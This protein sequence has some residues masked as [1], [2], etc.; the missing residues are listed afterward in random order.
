MVKDARAWLGRSGWMPGRLSFGVVLAALAAL[1]SFVWAAPAEAVVSGVRHTRFQTFQVF[2]DAVSVGNTLMGNTVSQPAVNSFLLSESQ[3]ILQGLPSNAGIEGAY[4]FWSGSTEGRPDR[5]ARLVLPNGVTRTVTADTCF[6][7]PVFGGFFYCR[8]DVTALLAANP[9]SA[10]NYNGTV[11][12]G[13]VQA[14]P[15]TLDE[16]GECIEPN[17]C[18]A[19]Y[20]AWSL[21]VVYTDPNAT[22]LRDVTIFDG[23][24]QFDE[25]FSSGI[26]TFAI[27]GFEVANPPQGRFAYFAMEGD[28]LLGV[29]PQ[30]VDSSPDVRCS[31]C[32]DF[33]DFNGTRL[34]DGRGWPN[35]LFNSTT[36]LGVD[37]DSF[38][39]SGLVRSG[40]RSVTITVGS[41]DGNP[42]FQGGGGESFFLGYVLLSLNR[43]APNFRTNATVKTV[44]PS[45]AG[46]GETVFFSITVTN[47]GSLDAT[48]V[49]L[50]DA[51][52]SNLIYVPGSTRVDGAAVADGPGGAAPFASGLSLGTIPFNGDND[53][54]VT[55]RATVRAGVA[56]GTVIPNVATITARELPEPTPTNEATIRVAAPTLGQPTKS[57]QDANG[58]S[59]EPGDIINYTIFI[60]NDSGRTA[61]A[62]T[63]VDDMPGFVQLRSVAPTP[64]TDRSDPNGGLNGTGR[65]EV[66]DILIPAN[67]SGVFI[68]Y[69]VQIDSVE[70]LIAQGVDPASIDGLTIVNQ[71]RVS[72]PF[73]SAALLTDNPATAATPDPTSFRITSS[74]N[75]QNPDTFKRVEDLN[76]GSLVPGDRLRYTISLRNTGNRATSINLS[77]DLPPFVEGFTLE[78]PLAEAT[79]APAPAGANATGRLTVTGL[80]VAGGSR[81][82][83][84]FTVTVR[85]DAPGGSRIGNVAQLQVPAAPTQSR[86]L[87]STVL[88]V[89]SGPDLSGATKEVVGAPPGGFQPGDEVTWRLAVTNTGNRAATNVRLDDDVALNLTFVSA[90]DGGAFNAAQRRVRWTLGDIAAGETRQVTVVTRINSPLANGTRIRNQGV[91]FADNLASG[92]VTDDPST[93]AVDDFTIITV[94]SEPSFVGTT[95]TVED[96]NGGEF[97]PGDR[98]RYRIEVRNT[99]R[100][101]AT[102]VALSDPVDGVRLSVESVGQ[103]GQLGG[104]VIQW[105]PATTPALASVAPGSSVVLDFTARL[106]G[107]LTN[108]EEVRNQGFI[109]SAQT[110]EPVGTD[111]PVTPEVG[112]PTSIF[113]RA[114]PALAGAIKSVVDENQGQPQPGDVL[115]WTIQLPNSGTGPA[116]GVVVSDVV[117]ASLTDVAPLDGGVFDAATRTITWRLAGPI[118]PG[119]Q[120]EVRFRSTIAPGTADG[121]A[122]SNQARVTT[123]DLPGET[124]LSDDPNTAAVDDPTTLVVR[125]QPDFVLSTKFVRNEDNPGAGFQPG[126]TISYELT[127]RNTGSQAGTA[128]Q[129][130]DD[131]PEGLEAIEVQDGGTLTGRQARWSLGTLA[132]GA[133]ETLL[134]R[135][136]IV[137]PIDDGTQIAN[138]AFISSAEVPTPVPTDNPNTAEE[139]D[140]TVF[141]VSSRPVFLGSRKLFTDL[142]AAPGEPVKPGHLLR[143]TIDVINSGTSS[144]RDVVVSDVVDA[145]LVDVTPE[146]GTF[147]AASRTIRWSAA[148]IPALANVAPDGQPIQVAFTARVRLPLDNGTLIA[149][150]ARIA[151]AEI[152]EGELSDDPRTADFPDATTA[153]VVSAADFTAATKAVSPPAA[154]VYRPGDEVTYTLSFTNN[155]DAV[156]SNVV[157]TDVLD[158]SLL[159]VSATDGGRFA[160]PQ[161]TWDRQST[162]ALASVAPGQTVVLR[163]TAALS[164]PLTNGLEVFNQ[165]RIT[166]EGFVNPVVTDDPSTDA[167]D[168]PTLLTVTS[169]PTLTASTKAVRDLDGDGFFEPG[170]VVE[171]TIRVQNDGSDE[172]RSTVVTDQVDVAS[173]EEVTPLDG[174][175]LQ[176]NTITWT[177]AGT[178]G[179][180]SVRPGAAG[181]VSV[182]FRATLQRGLL[183]GARILNQASLSA[184]GAEPTVTDDP[185]TPEVD[186]PTALR[187]TAAPRFTRFTKRVEDLNGGQIEGGDRLRY[188]LTATNDGTQPG[189]L[190]QINDPLDPNL[191]A[192]AA[193]DG[194]AVVGRA[195]QWSL[196]T[197]APGE[198]REVRFEATVRGGVEDGTAIVNQAGLTATS[199]P[200]VLSDDPSTPAEGDATVVVVNA[201]P[202][203]SALTMGVRVVDGGAVAPGALIEYELIVTNTGSGPGR[204]VILRDPIDAALLE[205]IQPSD[206]GRV[207]AGVV[208]WTAAELPILAAFPTTE[209]RRLT[210]R[211]RIREGLPNGVVILNQ[212][213]LIAQDTPE[214][215]SDDPTTAALDDPT[216]ITLAY[217]A[218]AA[219]DKEV[220]DVDGGLAEAG[221]QVEYTLTL[222]NDT[223][224]PLNNAVVEDTLDAALTEV[225]VEGGRFD[226]GTRLVR[227]DAGTNGALGAVAPGGQVALRF[228]ARIAQDAQPG[229]QIANQARASSPQ[230]AG[231]ERRSDD[232]NTAAV[233]DPTVITVQAPALA[234]LNNTTKLV[235]DENGGLVEPG[236]R[237]T[238]EITVRN[239]GRVAA[240]RVALLDPLPRLTRF[241]PGSLFVNGQAAP[242]AETRGQLLQLPLELPDLAPG[243][244]A[245]V[246]FSTEVSEEAPT[247]AVLTNQAIVTA[248]SGG[249][250]G[251]AQATFQVVTDDPTTSAVDDATQA[252]VGAGPNVSQ[253]SKIARIVDQN[254]NDRLDVGELLEYEIR[255]P[256]RGNLP[257]E[258][259]VLTDVLPINTTYMSGTLSIN[260]VAQTDAPGDDVLSVEG[261][262]LTARLGSIDPGTAPVIRFRVRT[263]R[264]PEVINQGELSGDNFP[265]EKT[266]A[267]GSEANGDQPTVTPVGS[268]AG[269]LVVGKVLSDV[270]G[271]RVA[272]GDTLL[273]TITITNA[274]DA[275]IEDAT[276]V[277]ELPAEVDFVDLALAPEGTLTGRRTLELAGFTVPPRESRTVVIRTQLQAEVQEGTRSCNQASVRAL[278]GTLN[279]SSDPAC[280]TVGGVLGAGLVSGLIFEDANANGV[281][282]EA[283]DLTFPNFLVRVFRAGASSALA[284]VVTGDDGGYNLPTLTEG[285]YTLRWF[286]QPTGGA[287]VRFGQIEGVSV[288]D[289]EVSQRNLR[290]DPS[291]RVYNAQ[292]GEV[293]SGA[294]VQLFYADEEPD[295]ALAGKLVAPQDL[296]EGQ[297]GQRTV[298]G[299]YRFDVVPGHVYRIAVVAPS[300]AFVFPSVRIPAEPRI[301]RSSEDPLLV[302]ESATPD[303]SGPTTWF[304]TFNITPDLPPEGVRN[305]HIPLDPL[306]GLIQVDKFASVRTATIGDVVTYTVRVTNRSSRDFIYDTSNNVG[307]IYIQDLLPRGFDYVKGS[308]RLRRIRGGQ[309]VAS[310]EATR[311]GALSSTFGLPVGDL[312]I[313]GP[314]PLELLAGEV[315]ELRYQL[316]VGID[317]KPGDDYLNRA[318]VV[319]ADGRVPISNEGLA[320]VRVTYD[321]IFDQGVVLGRVFCDDNAN[322]ELDAE[323][324]GVHRARVYLDNGWYAVTDA[325][326]LFHFQAVNPGNH[327]IKLDVNTLAPGAVLTTDVRRVFYTTRGLP[328]K[329]DFG[330][331]CPTHWVDAVDV[332][333]SAATQE[334]RAAERRKNFIQ[335]DGS[336]ATYEVKV[337]NEPLPLAKARLWIS[338]GEAA[339]EPAAEVP[340]VAVRGEKLE[341]PLVFNPRV[342]GLEGMRGWA[343]R[344]WRADAADKVLGTARLLTGSGPLPAAL[345]WEGQDGAAKVPVLSGPVG[346]LAEVVVWDADGNAATSAPAAFVV[347]GLGGGALLDETISGD[348]FVAKKAELTRELETRLGALGEKLRG[349]KAKI[350]ITVHTADDGRPEQA[351]ALSRERGDAVKRLLVARY[352]VAAADVEVEGLGDTRPLVPNIGNRERQI[353]RR[354]I[355]QATDLSPATVAGEAPSLPAPT[356]GVA[357]NNE[358]VEV[359]ADGAFSRLLKKPADGVLILVVRGQDGGAATRVLRLQGEAGA[360]A[361]PALLPMPVIPVRGDLKSGT[362][363][364]GTSTTTVGLLQVALKPGAEVY[365]L[366][367]GVLRPPAE[368]TVLAPAGLEVASYQLEILDADGKVIHA[369]TQS[370]GAPT[371]VRWTGAAGQGAFL[372]PGWY[373]AQLTLTT[374]DGQLGAS[375]PALFRVQL[376]APEPKPKPRRGA[377]PEIIPAAPTLTFAPAAFVNGRPAALAP[378]GSFSV[379]A[380]GYSGQRLVVEI[381]RADGARAIQYV[382]VPALY[383]PPTSATPPATP[384]APAEEAAPTDAAPEAAPAGDGASLPAAPVGPLGSAGGVLY[385][386]DSPVRVPAVASSPAAQPQVRLLLAQESGAAADAPV[387]SGAGPKEAGAL[388]SLGGAELEAALASGDDAER[389]RLLAATKA[390]N[391][392]VQ[393]PPQGV[394]LKSRELVVLG[395]TDPTNAITINGATVENLEGTFR[396][397]L[398]LPLGESEVVVEARDADGNTGVIRWPVKVAERA[399]FL[400]AFADTAVGA[401]GAEL[402]NLTA[403]NSTQA[404]GA[405]LYGEAKVYTKGYMSGRQFLDNFFSEYRYTAYFNSARQG[406]LEQFLTDTIK[407]DQYYPIFGDSAESTNDIN[408]RGKLYILVEAD[409]SRLIVGNARPNIQGVHFFRYDRPFYGA[410]LDFNKVLGQHYKT[411]VKAFVSDDD[412]EV[413]HTWNFLQGTGGSLYYLRNRDVVEGSEKVAVVIRDEASG[414]ELARVPMAR[415]VDYTVDYPSGRLLFKS[416]VPSV[417]RGEFLATRVATTR[418]VLDGNPVIVEVSYD[419]EVLAGDPTGTTFGGQV[420]ETLFDTVSVGAGYVEEGRGQGGAPA[421]RLWSVEAGAKYTERTRVDVEYTASESFDVAS[422]FSADGGLTFDTSSRRDGSTA[423]GEAW[424]VK[425]KVELGDLFYDEKMEEFLSISSYFQTT[426]PNFYS[427]GTI[428]EQGQDKFGGEAMWRITASNRLRLR[429]DGV[430]STVDDLQSPNPE[431]TRLLERQITT[432]QHVYQGESLSLTSE[433]NRTF[434]DDNTLAGGASSHTLG[435]RVTYRFTPNLSGFIGQQFVVEG[436]ERLYNEL[437]DRL[438]TDLG[439]SY[440]FFEDWSAEVIESLRW[441]GENATQLGL[442]TALTENTNLYLRER[443]QT[444]EDNSGV[445]TTSVVGGEQRFAGSSGRLY[446]EYQVD[447]GMIGDRSRAVIGIGKGFKLMDGLTLDVAYE[448]SQT[449]AASTVGE[450][451]RDVGSIGYELL[452]PRSLKFSQK[453]ELRY[454]EGDARFP[455]NNPCF[456]D[457]V[458]ANPDFCR[459]NFAGGQDK[460]QLVTTNNLVL[461]FWEDHNLLAK[462]DYAT[463][464]NLTFNLE[465]SSHLLLSFG[466]AL[467]PIHWDHLNVLLKYSYVEDLRP[468]SLTGLR[469]E[470]Q[471]A[472]VVSLVPIIELPFRLQ[473]VE[474]LAWKRAAVRYDDLPEV[475]SDTWLWINRLNYHLTDTFDASLEYRFLTNSLS[476]DVKHGALL[477]LSYILAEYARLGIGYNFT[478]FSDDELSDL[479][480]D[481][482]GFFF[483]VQGTY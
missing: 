142:D 81:V 361:N 38:D 123:V 6:T 323:E 258:G 325:N 423:S 265:P 121:T 150:Q 122:V 63:F 474:K 465:E 407:A 11:R 332:N 252:V 432:L 219:F 415:N 290:I 125:A 283:G 165:A 417:A 209:T 153:Q 480:R 263:E 197:V 243:E 406:E 374:A 349:K 171:Y 385:G 145:N 53:R 190:V 140:P 226:E 163:L 12:V 402:D 40:D 67:I 128:V 253:L 255:I 345:P 111:D 439:L 210:I 302:V 351:L 416:P 7:S 196:G 331:T 34:V 183:D 47:G 299:L 344:V 229:L 43:L 346:Y 101:V 375:A 378:D 15:G 272:P 194:G 107:T 476:Q 14:R 247:G 174:G 379:E 186:D 61:S 20:A 338:R 60:P 462:F 18:Q 426:T 300:Q 55:F 390:A 68:S 198:Q 362:L 120:A 314:R 246:R 469:E 279:V 26:D 112:D 201:E 310:Q 149:N 236:D 162:P 37:L 44:D 446:S 427:N 392:K 364:L 103:G 146:L 148:E 285:R 206:N 354:L 447:T 442:T 356:P 266:D 340:H 295:T 245:V 179:L 444:R 270:N 389:Q 228:T 52:N 126:D 25:D 315:I 342:E 422:F 281:F 291:G 276:L 48:N 178:P 410:M 289:G 393:L 260:G 203:F 78:T 391:L 357:L 154:G 167:L 366:D 8:A 309:P 267:D 212:V 35:N 313:T 468:V 381:R 54:R 429:H 41:G 318:S 387:S 329:V 397:V 204:D 211:A 200:Q 386:A 176:G 88:T 84:R 135:A 277:D 412:L 92:V 438:Q 175:R 428:L 172:A 483:R 400:M 157:V 269:S 477:E 216:R 370:G 225:Q 396:H 230:V 448:H 284:E 372:A 156:A 373:R 424:A 303:L 450:Q 22:T 94:R 105:T 335:V 441:N 161:V 322:G 39:V 234:D 75:F 369:D 50:R 85:D 95:K 202:D 398:T 83:L 217:P 62:V 316:L 208:T 240:T 261:S 189:Q 278:A 481:V 317:T 90:T 100:E 57:F 301:W 308:A 98:V 214:V 184:E 97:E 395:T 305:N 10:G 31:D 452:L 173:L 433:Y 298:D 454:D 45:E 327:L 49:V 110:P 360:S 337:D 46:P 355:L 307:G 2:G 328:T 74:I 160:A 273:Y 151:S 166:A 401:E 1:A 471:A 464:E 137:N 139:D 136:R 13:D 435:E 287:P 51:L 32:F 254:G 130:I 86:A 297:Q 232:P 28:E 116:R 421:Y 321:P 413:A 458:Y 264:G 259:A 79:F 113:I 348:V 339:A 456:G 479:N 82:E 158:P 4:L 191:E 256:N 36:S 66:R 56:G 218:I 77:D 222:R 475:E 114:T 127:V 235:I 455:Q 33:M 21:A 460:L 275:L 341:A 334:A 42:T 425:G 251:G 242:G 319:L 459:D 141:A 170:D 96:L 293:I 192:V 449:V 333:E 431:A 168:D 59:I 133:E 241:I 440:R 414:I 347:D 58:G 109:V 155:G 249:D 23:F 118:P 27:D 9:A 164:S 292:S 72:A 383:P 99:G 461:T 220:R 76:G 376:A 326:G 453:L 358:R 117:S 304:T 343:I 296:P 437:S 320:R 384:P 24:R 353:N 106:A 93:A 221:D 224:V 352:G 195:V 169:A 451:S 274:S 330:A 382:E 5:D 181:V 324:R 115:T 418:Q 3:A 443:I 377:P 19:F 129:V 104:G 233:Q 282:D 180:A 143:W 405:F 29:P 144:A 30:D 312:K 463:T 470:R 69:S 239:E 409:A 16:N 231:L 199:V 188:T 466:Y 248:Q 205:D 207:E 399:M 288:G 71:G 365:S 182:R 223:G 457:G 64:Y 134:I 177:S 102:G 404:G 132:P 271:G 336:A 73:L 434:F 371:R 159:F 213:N 119:E 152:P 420:R 350:K 80:E 380:E 472:H 65:V 227:F 138:Q 368:F 294:E 478:R 215:L 419:Y 262:V 280:F 482:G 187:V 473:L 91:L 467:R 147:D 131:L 311:A 359:G 185:A 17:L 87:A 250:V 436:D 445:S 411:E 89:T 237:L 193:Q 306:S 430:I 124:I 257:T 244:S 394:E 238:W 286:T 403:A 108:G 70:E 408:A 363:N 268:R 388:E 367:Q